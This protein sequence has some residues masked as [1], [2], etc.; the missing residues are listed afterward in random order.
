MFN[1]PAVLTMCGSSKRA[2]VF[3]DNE[4][5]R[6]AFTFLNADLQG[7]FSLRRLSAGTCCI[8]GIRRFLADSGVLDRVVSLNRKEFPLRK[9]NET[10]EGFEGSELYV[11]TL[12]TGML[13]PE[14]KRTLESEKSGLEKR[15]RRGRRRKG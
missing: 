3:Y 11:A 9:L 15:R 1:I 7:S 8:H 14:E 12:E 5:Y 4:K 2:Y 13:A 6:V 10:V